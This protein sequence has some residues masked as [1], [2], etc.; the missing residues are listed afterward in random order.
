MLANYVTQPGDWPVAKKPGSE[1][2][3][4]PL[5]ADRDASTR[6]LQEA[7]AWLVNDHLLSFTEF[8]L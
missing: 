1:T 7:I 5:E 8:I 6:C 3:T 2:R 4:N